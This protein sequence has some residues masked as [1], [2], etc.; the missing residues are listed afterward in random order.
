[1]ATQEEIKEVIDKTDVVAVVSRYLPLEKS[2]KNYRGLC[3]FHSEKTPSFFVSPDKKLA[4]CFGCGGGGTI[5]DFVMQIEGIGFNEALSK[6]ADEAGIKVSNAHTE[7]VNPTIKRYHEIMQSSLEFYDKFLENTD[8]GIEAKK[9]LADRGI[10]EEIIKE[11]KIGVAPKIGDTLYRFLKE[12]GYYE[13]DMEDVGLVSNSGKGYHDIFANRIMFPIFDEVGNVVAYSGRIYNPKDKNEPKYIN[14]PETPIFKKNEILFNL[15]NAKGFIRK[16]DRVVLHEGQ[17]DVIAS[18]KCGLKEVVCSLGTALTINHVN[19]LKK[20]TKN[21]IIAYDGDKAGINASKKAIKL[22][23]KSG[24][25]VRVVLFPDGMDP[26][27]YVK[28]YQAKGYA[29]FLNENILDAYEYEFRV[30]LIGKDLSDSIVLEAV[31][32]EVFEMIHN[33]PSNTLKDEYLKKL[34][35]SLN[36][37]EL[38]LSNDFDFYNRTHS[39]KRAVVEPAPTYDDVIEPE[40][41]NKNGWNSLCEIRLFMYAKKSKEEAL[42]IDSLIQDEIMSAFSSS[43]INLWIKLINDYYAYNDVYNDTKFIKLLDVNELNYYFEILEAVRHDKTAYN[44]LDENLC[45]EHIKLVAVEKEIERL[46]KLIRKS[47]P[48]KKAAYLKQEFELKRKLNQ[49]IK[50]NKS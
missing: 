41:I 8:I 5:I 45:I 16:N 20:Y 14:S 39:S 15:N 28:K 34:A 26:D 13:L 46:D 24:F 23:L 17:M 50:K 22:F 2:G 3:P 1:M 27:E 44:D 33:L 35:K 40:E 43:S 29:S 9:Y 12:F 47:S 31:K 36:V 11:F 37:G 42:R 25:N 19:L 30:S 4:K 38:S 6:L 48:E 32:N 7:E 18:S 10:N 21:V 49:L